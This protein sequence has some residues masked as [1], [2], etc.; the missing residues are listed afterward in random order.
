MFQVDFG[1]EYTD[2]SK[3]SGTVN[4]MSSPNHKWFIPSDVALL[5]NHFL[6]P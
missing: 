3:F 2:G 6:V 1:T 4:I 5:N